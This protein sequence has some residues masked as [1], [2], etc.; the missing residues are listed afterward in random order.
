[1]QKKYNPKRGV[2]SGGAAGS[3]RASLSQSVRICSVISGVL[4]SR[5]E[6]CERVRCVQMQ[7]DGAGRPDEGAAA[8]AAGRGAVRAAG[9]ADGAPPPLRQGGQKQTQTRHLHHPQQQPHLR[10]ERQQQHEILGMR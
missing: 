6:F 9:R 8:A 10:R 5:Q 4:G 3:A 2:K 1:M 7:S